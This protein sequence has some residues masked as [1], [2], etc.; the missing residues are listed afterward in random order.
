MSPIQNDLI[1][2]YS[3]VFVERLGPRSVCNLYLFSILAN[4]PT[5][6]YEYSN[7]SY[8]D[9]ELLKQK[10]SELLSLG[11]LEPSGFNWSL[12]ARPDFSVNNELVICVD[13]GRLNDC[14]DTFYRLPSIPALLDSIPK[15]SVFSKVRTSFPSILVIKTNRLIVKS[16][17]LK[18]RSEGRLSPACFGRE[19]EAPDW[20][21][22]GR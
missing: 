5:P 22:G 10:V 3:D 15:S 6:L 7:L 2:L 19:F 11:Y 4:V 1:A 17:N 9:N 14:T 21:S 18:D 8:Q 13:Y 20:L 16:S 12:P